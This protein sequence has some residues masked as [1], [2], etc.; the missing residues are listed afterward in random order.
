M[1]SFAIVLLAAIALS[2]TSAQSS[3][4]TSPWS[5]TATMGWTQYAMAGARVG[6]KVYLIGDRQ[7]LHIYDITANSW[8]T[9]AAVPNNQYGP[10][11]AAGGKVYVVGGATGPRVTSDVEVYD[12]TANSW[13]KVASLPSA[14]GAGA[15][16]VLSGKIHL[17]G[18][19]AYQGATL[20]D[21]TDHLVYDPATNAW[22][23]LAPMLTARDQLALVPD[24]TG[25]KLYA[26][27]GWN[28]TTVNASGRNEA[29]NPATDTW[30]KMPSM[31]TPRMNIGAALLNGYIY[32][33]GG[34][35]NRVMY[36]GV[37]AY[38]VQS[39]KWTVTAPLPAA[40]PKASAI[41]YNGALYVT[42]G[43]VCQ[44]GACYG[45]NKFWTY[46]PVAPN[47]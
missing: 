46:T 4:A 28:T 40:R 9:G 20:V 23:K 34:A 36:S 8:S 32:A 38:N 27:G 16:A 2:Q 41:A 14:R 6:H 29:Y 35:T 10:I 33:A 22:S 1:K 39:G 42:G 26:I 37:E 5:S 12:P 19:R 11:V 13:T 15:A 21:V 17:V 3:A 45:T 24:P 18:G 30:T 31:P 47:P 7:A 44:D 25:G 43:N